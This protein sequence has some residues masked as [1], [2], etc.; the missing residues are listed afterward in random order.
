MITVSLIAMGISDL[1]SE[2]AITL[3][4]LLC[5]PIIITSLTESPQLVPSITVPFTKKGLL[6]KIAGRLL[7]PGWATGLLFVLLLFVLMEIAL[8]VTT[9]TTSRYDDDLQKVILV[10]FASLLLPVALTRIFAKKSEN[11][12]GLFLSLIHI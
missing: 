3:G 5:I 2:V 1:D 9:L 7:Y 11:R 6:G 8:F 4:V 10:I 12:F